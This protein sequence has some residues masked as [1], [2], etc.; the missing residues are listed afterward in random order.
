MLAGSSVHFWTVSAWGNFLEVP[1]P[2]L[3]FITERIV[4][5]RGRSTATP[6]DSSSGEREPPPGLNQTTALPAS[7]HDQGSNR[8]EIG[9]CVIPKGVFSQRNTRNS[10]GCADVVGLKLRD[11]AK[12]IFTGLS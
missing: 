10:G 5:A 9:E 3:H 11:G 6:F 1:S 12:L 8:F 2:G 7:P 4:P